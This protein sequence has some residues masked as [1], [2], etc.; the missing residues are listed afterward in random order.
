MI[1]QNFKETVRKVKD[2]EDLLGVKPG[3]G[4][5]PREAF[6]R[7]RLTLTKQEHIRNEYRTIIDKAE[8][9]TENLKEEAM[10]LN[11]QI[12]ILSEDPESQRLEEDD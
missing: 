6:N 10:K 12:G 1:R 2:L 4:V 8:E 5:T 3:K 7:M 9:E 11:E